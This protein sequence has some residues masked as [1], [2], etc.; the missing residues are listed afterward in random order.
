M[1]DSHRNS[2]IIIIILYLSTKFTAFTVSAIKALREEVRKYQQM[3][4]ELDEECRSVTN[5]H[6]THHQELEQIKDEIKVDYCY[7]RI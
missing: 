4:N 6:S 7:V 2:G 5:C 3:N 1:D